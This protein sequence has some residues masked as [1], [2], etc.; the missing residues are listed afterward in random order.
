MTTR[1]QQSATKPVVLAIAE[2]ATTPNPGV[3]NAVAFSSTTLVFMRWNGSA[4]TTA[5]G[6]TVESGVIKHTGTAQVTGRLGIGP[7]PSPA[8]PI[9]ITD[10]VTAAIR[11]TKTGS[12]AGHFEIYNDGFANI[13]GP[14]TSPNRRYSFYDQM[15][16]GSSN[17]VTNPPFANFADFDTGMYF[18]DNSDKVAL[19]TGGAERLRAT[20]TGVTVTGTLAASGAVSDSGSRV[21]SP[22]NP[23]RYAAT[24]KYGV[25]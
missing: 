10:S 1:A 12:N 16:S 4:W 20:N 23:P 18:P 8:A 13:V 17:V 2:G 9:H 25:D 24:M 19:V 5:T 6:T 21:Y 15:C 22:V 7:T 11:L 3:V 14:G